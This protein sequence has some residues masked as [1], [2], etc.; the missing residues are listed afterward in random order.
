LNELLIENW[1]EMYDA[2]N[3]DLA[4]RFADRGIERLQELN[5]GAES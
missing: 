4:V 1:V 2:G 5:D 3:G